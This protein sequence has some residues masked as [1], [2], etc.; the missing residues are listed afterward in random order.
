MSLKGDKKIIVIM[1]LWWGLPLLELALGVGH[2][3]SN[4]SVRILSNSAALSSISCR[5]AAV[6]H[7]WIVLHDE[8]ISQTSSEFVKKCHSD[9]N[10]NDFEYEVGDS[11]AAREACID[12]WIE[13]WLMT[14][15]LKDLTSQFNAWMGSVCASELVRSNVSTLAF[16]R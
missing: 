7:P 11:G 3:L 12:F 13:S 16:F 8:N 5:S 9:L 14:D 15:H 10:V 6:S 2:S 4:S 1:L